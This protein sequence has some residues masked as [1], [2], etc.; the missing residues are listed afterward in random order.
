[1]QIA[2]VGPNAALLVGTYLLH[3]QFSVCLTVFYQ[4]PSPT[5]PRHAQD[6]QLRPHMPRQ[7]HP[8]QTTPFISAQAGPGKGR[9]MLELWGTI[10]RLVGPSRACGRSAKGFHASSPVVAPE[11]LP[12]NIRHIIGDRPGGTVGD[13]PQNFLEGTVRI[14]RGCFPRIPP[15][16]PWRALGVS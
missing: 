1:M 12:R 15:R 4:P 13:D 16:Y 14:P 11:G 7:A 2:V 10:V 5:R 3:C 9:T 8:N 6:A